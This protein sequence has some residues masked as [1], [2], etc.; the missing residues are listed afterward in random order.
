M[1]SFESE[2]S[3][4]NKIKKRACICLGGVKTGVHI[5]IYISILVRETNSKENATKQT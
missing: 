2:G 5:Y 4:T 1:R 3:I